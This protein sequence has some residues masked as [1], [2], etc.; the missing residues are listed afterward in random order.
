MCVVLGRFWGGRFSTIVTVRAEHTCF[1]CVNFQELIVNK[2]CVANY[3]PGWDLHA[4]I[5]V[6]NEFCH[7][8]VVVQIGTCSCC[9][10]A[11]ATSREG[12]CHDTTCGGSDQGT[13]V[14][15]QFGV[16]MH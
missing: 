14:R 3:F 8:V 13:S 7:E 9:T 10:V 6:V 16:S 11:A 15:Y 5:R 2:L 12:V 4:F 1:G